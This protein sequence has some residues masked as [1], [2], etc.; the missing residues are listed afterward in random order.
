MGSIKLCQ[1][2]LLGKASRRSGK[3]GAQLALSIGDLCQ[4][5]DKN[6]PVLTSG[7]M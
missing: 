3:V 7:H 2:H 4:N 6:I 5:R 1:D